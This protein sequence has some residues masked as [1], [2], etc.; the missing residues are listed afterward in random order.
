MQE[1]VQGMQVADV[2]VEGAGGAGGQAHRCAPAL[3]TAHRHRCA[4]G[5]SQMQDLQE[6][7]GC[8]CASASVREV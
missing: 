6:V 2:D 1:V 5:V 3:H 8:K 4:G 7:Q